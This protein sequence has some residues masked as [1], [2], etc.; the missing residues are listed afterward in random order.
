MK[1]SLEAK[2]VWKQTEGSEIHEN[3]YGI[4]AEMKWMN[5]DIEHLLMRVLK[6]PSYD[7]IPHPP[8]NH[9]LTVAIILIYLL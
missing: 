8:F 5:N 9:L 7:Y 1:T 4:V 6:V 3:V 2:D